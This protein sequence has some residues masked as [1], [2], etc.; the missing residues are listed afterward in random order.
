MV[1]GLSSIFRSPAQVSH[2]P[3]ACLARL[4]RATRNPI[5]TARVNTPTVKPPPRTYPSAPAAAKVSNG[6]SLTLV[7]TASWSSLVRSP[8]LESKSVVFKYPHVKPLLEPRD[9]AA[10]RVSSGDDKSERR[11]RDNPPRRPGAAAPSDTGRD[12]STLCLTSL[13]SLY[14]FSSLIR[15]SSRISPFARH[16]SRRTTQR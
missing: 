9:D 1:R 13:R 8:T 15:C 16:E 4:A 3:R 2:W 14:D 5:C 10:D 6:L 11:A 12:L 7:R